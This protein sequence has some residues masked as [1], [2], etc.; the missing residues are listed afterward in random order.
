MKSILIFGGTTEE[1][2][3]INQLKD[4]V[5]ITLCV[6]SEYAAKLV[7]CYDENITILIGRKDYNEIVELLSSNKYDFVIDATHPYAKIVTENLIKATNITQN[8]YL[9]L[10]REKSDLSD[11]IVVNSI[12]DAAE[13][14]KKTQ[15]N[16]M[17]TTGSKELSPFTAIADFE[18]RIY[19]R[20]LPMVES[21]EAC[22]S[23]GFNSSHIIAMQG[24]FSHN[25]NVAL[26]EQ[27]SIKTMVTK[28]GGTIG[29]FNE[30][31]SAAKA[32]GAEIIVIKRNEEAGMSVAQILAKI[33]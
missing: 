7:D 13:Y 32:T 23:L 4:K 10:I 17:L 20:V 6:T 8:N 2:Y 18:E 1:H 28:D 19:P 14:L 12:N 5:K 16:I 11:C 22:I 31:L 26:L 21:I 3:L 30:K 25:L 24:P 27:Y 33:L 9:R 29:G 15:G